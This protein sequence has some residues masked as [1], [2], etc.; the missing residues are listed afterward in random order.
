MPRQHALASLQRLNNSPV[1]ISDLGLRPGLYRASTTLYL[2]WCLNN[3]RDYSRLASFVLFMHQLR[4]LTSTIRFGLGTAA[5]TAAFNTLSSTDTDFWRN[6]YNP[7]M[8]AWSLP[9][10]YIY[11]CH[12][13]ELLRNEILTYEETVHTSSGGYGVSENLALAPERQRRRYRS[14]TQYFAPYF[15]LLSGA[16][17][18]EGA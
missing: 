8:Q 11:Y 6:Y 18:Q 2:R 15:F 13:P 14:S 5:T 9:T 10:Q 1:S 17:V 7:T 12:R 4:R 3:G 16:A